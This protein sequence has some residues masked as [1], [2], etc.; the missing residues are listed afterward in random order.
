MLSTIIEICTAE[1]RPP[2]GTVKLN[3]TARKLPPPLKVP[4]ILSGVCV[5]LGVTPVSAMCPG[6]APNGD[7]VLVGVKLAVDVEEIEIDLVDEMEGEGVLSDDLVAVAVEVGEGE[8]EI[9]ELVGVSEGIPRLIG[10]LV[11]VTVGWHCTTTKITNT[12]NSE[13]QEVFATIVQELEKKTNDT[14]QA[15]NKAN[16][17]PQ[18]KMW[19]KNVECTTM[20]QL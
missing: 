17:Q 20:Q 9:G 1:Q 11:R 12:T 6:P 15:S 18:K 3:S 5:L 14:C 7:C 4:L 13:N 19:F 8:V 16:P 2:Q 10:V